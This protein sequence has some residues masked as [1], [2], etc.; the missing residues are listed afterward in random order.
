M[1]FEKL[2]KLCKLKYWKWYCLISGFG[3]GLIYLPAIVSVTCYFE[4]Y[5]SLATGIAVCGSGLGTFVFAPVTQKLITYLGWRQALQVLS[6]FVFKCFIYGILFRPLEP[7]NK[8]IPL[9]EIQPVK[10]SS[11]ENNTLPIPRVVT[12]AVMNGEEQKR[13]H[14]VHT[15]VS[16]K[17][18]NGTAQVAQ[19]DEDVV[20]SSLSQPMLLSQTAVGGSGRVRQISESSSVRS[21]V[22]GVMYRKDVLYRGSLHT[23]PPESR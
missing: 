2:I 23:I 4:K 12:T 10:Y 21:A 19:E 13:P 5:R 11:K 15:F 9:E 8:A 1:S 7:A 16:Q 22:S 17:C 14:S 6:I 18:A 3:F 20:K